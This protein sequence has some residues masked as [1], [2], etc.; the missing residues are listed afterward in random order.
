VNTTIALTVWQDA[1]RVA[2][3]GRSLGWFKDEVSATSAAMERILMSAD[4]WNRQLP[5]EITIKSEH[6]TDWS[7]AKWTDYKRATR[8]KFLPEGRRVVR[9]PGTFGKAWVK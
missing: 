6:R 4:V 1:V 2:V 5:S 9:V 3:D 7:R 8:V